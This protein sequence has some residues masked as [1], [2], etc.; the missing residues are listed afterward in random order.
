[1]AEG[2]KNGNDDKFSDDEVENDEV[3]FEIQSDESICEETEDSKKTREERI[4]K[5]GKKEKIVTD[6]VT[7]NVTDPAPAKPT[8]VNVNEEIAIENNILPETTEH[9]QNKSDIEVIEV[10]E[11]TSKE[12]N[13]AAENILPKGQ[14]S[15]K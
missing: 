3:T 11:S 7:D 10:C 14:P 12:F 13:F 5:K 15:A 1:M 2:P 8:W 9:S 6:A 4:Q